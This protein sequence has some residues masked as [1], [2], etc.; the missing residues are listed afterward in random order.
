M[1][2]VYTTGPSVV[3]VKKLL[4]GGEPCRKCRDIEQRLR[5][6]GLMNRIDEIQVARADDPASPGV[7]LAERLG[8][9]RA[10]FFVIRHPDGGERVIESYLAFKRWLAGSEATAG[11]LEEAVDRH[12]EL[13][14]L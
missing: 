8:V 13:A 2:A 10:P 12:P 6:D 3:F 1:R 7:M 4:P 11:D 14:F 5:F 9:S